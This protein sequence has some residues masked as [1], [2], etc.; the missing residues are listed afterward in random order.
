MV[1]EVAPEQAKE[2]NQNIA[3]NYAVYA[4]WYMEDSE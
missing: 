4:S 3:H 1:K 2:I